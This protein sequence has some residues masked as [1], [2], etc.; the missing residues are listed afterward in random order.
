MTVDVPLRFDR[1]ELFP[2]ERVLLR[3]GEVVPL[4][5]RAFDLLLALAERRG[6]L[7]TKSELLDK[8]WP[9]LVVEENNIAAQVV[10]L[11]KALRS[12]L[13]VTVPGRGYRLDDRAK[14]SLAAT[15]FD[16]VN[17]LRSAQDPP[18]PPYAEIGRAHV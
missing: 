9:R 17:A 7:V 2:N 3:D 10:A 5:A 4:R 13:I 1:F 8:V 18:Q 6:H 15:R 16:A 12:D 11:R 14:G